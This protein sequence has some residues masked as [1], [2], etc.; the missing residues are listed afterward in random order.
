MGKHGPEFYDDDTVFA[1]YMSGRETRIDSPNETLEKPVI[2]ELVGKV[3][4]L[5]ILDLGCG[6]AMFGIEALQQ[7][8][9]SYLGIDGSQNMVKAAQE[10]LSGTPGKVIYKNIET[11]HYP[12]HQFDLVISRLALHYVQEIERVFGKVYQALVEGGRFIFSVEHPVITSCDRA[13]QTSGPRQDWIVD[14]YFEVG[15]RVTNWMGGEVIKYH[16]T[17]EDYFAGLR[18]T[19]FVVDALRESRPQRL[20][21][22]DEA[23]YERRKRIPLML[24]FSASRPLSTLPRST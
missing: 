23:T 3:A 8:C 10:K 12:L 24:F 21:F 1:T 17:I 5:R 9:Q 6:N 4:D 13:W 15:P 19:G 2:D 22:R 7:G 20:R 14:N 18:A 16:R 11:W